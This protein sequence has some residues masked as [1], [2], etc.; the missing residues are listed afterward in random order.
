MI[1]QPLMVA[2]MSAAHVNIENKE[3]ALHSSKIRKSTGMI[4]S[5][6]QNVRTFEAV[7]SGK[8]ICFGSGFVEFL[9]MPIIFKDRLEKKTLSSSMSTEPKIY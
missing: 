7:Q 6:I 3:K 2:D 8:G 4:R 5:I 1:L 9:K